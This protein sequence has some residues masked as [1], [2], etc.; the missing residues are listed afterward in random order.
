MNQATLPPTAASS[1]VGFPHATHARPQLALLLLL[2]GAALLAAPLLA[3]LLPFLG[4]A[5]SWVWLSLPGYILSLILIR[6]LHPLERLPIA[7]VLGKG[8]A[9]LYTVPAILGHASLPLLFAASVVMLA[10][11]L[12][13]Y[14]LAQRRGWGAWRPAVDESVIAQAPPP[15]Q[16]R[17]LVTALAGAV[18]LV[19]I[20]L[21]LLSVQWPA[22]GDDLAMLPFF[23]D[24]LQQGAI[25]NTEPFH[26]S[27]NPVLTRQELVVAV[28]QQIMLTWLTGLEPVDFYLYTRPVFILLAFLGLYALLRHALRRPAPALFILFLWSLYLLG[29]LLVEQTGSHFVTR[30]TQDKFEGWFAV[31]PPTLLLLMRFLESGSWVSSVGP[32]APPPP[33]PAHSHAYLVAFALATLGATFV[34]AITLPQLMTL[35]GSLWLLHGVLV[36]RRA[37][38]ALGW[39]ALVYLVCLIVP[40]IEYLRFERERLILDALGLLEVERF[41][42][43]HLAL[44]W[45]RLLLLPGNRFIVGPATFLQPVHYAGYLALPA[46]I[47]QLRRSALARLLLGAMLLLPLFLYTP[48]L[49]GLVGQL[50]PPSLM[51]RLAWPF[52]LFSI[53]AVGWAIWLGLEQLGQVIG[54][55]ARLVTPVKTGG[56][57]ITP[58]GLSL[59]SLL[60]VVFAFPTLRASW[61]GYQE[62]VGVEALSACSAAQHGL[63]DRLTQLS[64]GRPITVLATPLLNECLP[65]YI[66]SVQ[67][68]EYRDVATMARLY[69]VESREQSAQRVYDVTAF[70]TADRLDGTLLDALARWQVAY[71]LVD[72]DQILLAWQLRSL[73][74]LFTPAFEDERYILYAVSPAD[75][76]AV[77]QPRQADRVNNFLTAQR[78]LDTQHF[79]QAETQFRGCLE[80]PDLCAASVSL[81]HVGLAQALEGQGRLDEALAHWQAAVAAE[82][83]SAAL[84]VYLGQTHLLHQQPQAAIAAYTQALAVAPAEPPPS[85][86]NQ[87]ALAQRLA[88][89]TAAAWDSYAAGQTTRAPAGSATWYSLMGDQMLEHGWAA[90]AARSYEQAI[91]VE[92]TSWRYVSLGAARYTAGD[93]VG[94]LQAIVTARQRD[95][96]LS[97]APAQLAAIYEHQGWLDEAV[98]AYE[99]ALWLD[100]TNTVAFRAL[101]QVINRRHGLP[102]AVDET[103]TWLGVNDILPGPHDA[104]ADLYAE[105]GNYAAAVQ[106]LQFS[107]KVIPTNA[108][109]LETLGGYYFQ[110]E[111]FEAARQAYSDALTIYP[112]SPTA[113][114]G[115]NQLDG[116]NLGIDYTVGAQVALARRQPAAAQPHLSLAQL[117]QLAGRPASTLTR[118]QWA[119]QLNPRN[120]DAHLALGDLYLSQPS[121]WSGPGESWE[122][123]Q[124]SYQQAA[125]LTPAQADPHL[126]LSALYRQRGAPAEAAAALT[127]AAARQPTAAATLLAQAEQAQ[128]AGDWEAAR[129]LYGHIL[130]RRPHTLEA[131]L[132][133][134]ALERNQSQPQAA[135]DTLAVALEQHITD[136]NLYLAL[137][138]LHLALGRP[139]AAQDWYQAGVDNNPYTPVAYLG[140]AT[141][142]RR[143]GAWEAAGE[144]Y[145][146]ALRLDPQQAGAAIGLASLYEGQGEPDLAEDNFLVAIAAQPAS[147]WAHV[148]LGNF[149]QRQGRPAEAIA[150]YTAAQAAEPLYV[151]SYLALGN[152]YVLL[153]RPAEAEAQY[154]QATT[155]LPGSLPAWIGLGEFYNAQGRTAEALAAYERAAGLEPNHVG[156][157][158]SLGRAYLQ[159]G[160][161][162]AANDA[163]Q[164]AVDLAPGSAGAWY[165]LAQMHISRSQLPEAQSALENARR[166]HHTLPEVHT[167]LGDVWLR[168]G[169]IAQAITAYNQA[170]AAAPGRIDGLLRLA[171]LHQ[172]Q[173]AYDLALESYTT[174]QL[175][176]P[177]DSRP[178]LGLADIYRQQ[179]LL[180]TAEATLQ[181]GLSAVPGSGELVEQ[182]G[183]LYL[184]QGRAN[185][186]EALYRL[187]L[188]SENGGARLVTP[189]KTGGGYD[190]GRP[191][192]ALAPLS[193]SSAVSLAPF[194]SCPSCPS[195]FV[196]SAAPLTGRP[197]LHIALGSLLQ[198]RGD[199]AEAE[200][201]YRAAILAQ[202]NNARGYLALANLHL[203]LGDWQEVNNTYEAA[204]G[205]LP[206][207]DALQAGLSR[208]L[209]AQGE[210][211]SALTAAQQAVTYNGSAANLTLL[212]QAYENLGDFTPAQNAYESVI[213]ADYSLPDGYLALGRLHSRLGRLEEADVAFRQAIAITYADVE[214]YWRLGALQETLGRPAGAEEMY[215]LSLAA[216]S[217]D[218]DAH[219]RLAAFL[220]RQNRPQEAYTL[221]QEAL[222]LAP[223]RIDVHL[224]LANWYMAAGDWAAAEE[225]LQGAATTYPTSGL[226][227][228]A[229]ADFALQRGR[230]DEAEALYQQVALLPGYALDGAIALGN[231]HSARGRLAE[232]EAAFE[233]AIAAQPG[234]ARGYLALAGYYTGHG[235]QPE[236]EQVILGALEKM[237]TVE[238]LFVALANSQVQQGAH[239]AAQAT[240]EAGLRYHPTSAD[241]LLIRLDAC[242]QATI[243]VPPVLTQ[244]DAALART[245]G[246]TSLHRAQ[247]E[248]RLAAGDLTGAEAAYQQALALT[249]EEPATLIGLAQ[250]A[251]MQGATEAMLDYYAQAAQAS[252][253]DAVTLT[254]IGQAQ[255]ATGHLTEAA[256]AFDLALTANATYPGAQVGL[257][258]AL[259]GQGLLAEA[260]RVY[261]QAVA[262]NPGS[263]QALT[264][265]GNFQL[266]HLDQPTQALTLYQ[267]AL[268]VDATFLGAHIGLGRAYD[269]LGEFTAGLAAYEQGVAL[270]PSQ[271]WGYTAL[272][273]AYRAREDYPAAIA[274]HQ[275]ALALDPQSTSAHLALGGVYEAAGQ[276]DAA[277]AAYQAAAAL[278]PGSASAQLALGNVY[279]LQ[280][281]DTAA[282]TA[283][284]QAL[285]LDPDL[286]LAHER[287]G[288]FYYTRGN[289]L[290]AITYLSQAVALDKDSFSAPFLLALAYEKLGDGATAEVYFGVTLNRN[291]AY[292]PAFQGLGRTATIAGRYD[293]AIRHYT[294]ANTLAEN[295]ANY[296]AL[297]NVYFN[298]LHQ[299]DLAVA[300]YRQGI[301]LDPGC[302]FCYVQIGSVY[303]AQQDP[304]AAVAIYEAGIAAGASTGYLHNA[305]GGAYVALGE[306]EA[307]RQAYEAAVQ[308]DHRIVGA[309]NGIIAVFGRYEVGLGYTA[310]SDLIPTYETGGPYPLWQETLL[311][312][313]FSHRLYLDAAK[314]LTHFQQVEAQDPGFVAIYRPM[315][316]LYETLG[317][318]GQALTYWQKFLPGAVGEQRTEAENAIGRLQNVRLSSPAD[319][320]S[321]S[322]VVEVRGTAS[323]ANF[324][325]Y[326]VEY[327]YG[328]TPTTWLSI[329]NGVYVV[330]VHNN[331]LAYWDTT[332]LPAGVYTLRLTLVYR[333]GNTAPPDL[334]TVTVIN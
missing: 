222:T 70:A 241:L 151:D 207:S 162:V 152:L 9:T 214:P 78:A 320:Q 180:A 41:G 139:E 178:Y 52:P 25:S 142:L 40:I 159:S 122:G 216:D 64:A 322:G 266:N 201:E 242:A 129:T 126:R 228:D 248:A 277:V 197:G 179:G 33:Q 120:P 130:D 171:A 51:W 293:D 93:I 149:Y 29:T 296:L 323:A 88:G 205:V 234:N 74:A 285:A 124:A 131:Y 183:L 272:G 213:R 158:L 295:S 37:W 22:H 118:L 98:Q 115:L 283:Y 58:V 196:P 174:A 329:G 267:Q 259:E 26:G 165:A 203:G 200:A 275:Q 249:P 325:F 202:P 212:G 298:H 32:L 53:I 250:L 331:V 198:Q 36:G 99:R 221:Y 223:A 256:A 289:Y 270:N 276:T 269:A 128:T 278:D 271:A 265:L 132:A 150:T 321:V 311:G 224:A 60:V 34:H 90:E 302:E 263:P 54:D 62:R 301:A 76:A 28:Y 326:K 240:A 153:E 303:L 65:S 161:L 229:L 15:P 49:A 46:L 314:A 279:A 119:I 186:A 208:A 133:L 319:N 143:Q 284:E 254:Q 246:L 3:R 219:L 168:Q 308:R 50:V 307:A 225:T 134:S 109:Y 136:P 102:A 82:P 194:S 145:T 192:Q 176:Q 318:G 167:L 84:H 12:V 56:G 81:L 188:Y 312:Y 210:P 306:W 324:Q 66:G 288:N 290:G 69:A 114:S 287:L 185:D 18:A 310:V 191:L 141:E 2:S 83:D 258:Q 218:V 91:A 55:K 190:G 71:V 206:G 164:R 31:I 67:V 38:R 95:P 117:D 286:G 316:L 170:V 169:Q 226:A 156:L 220:E 116:R 85:L 80:T 252:L 292:A 232:A 299:P 86:W 137:G 313:I 75:A 125:A 334:V 17:L 268:A 101:A 8:L 330:P 100:P 45:E 157:W 148:A 177:A 4:V 255:L 104:L 121:L 144:A 243:C 204:L 1:G 14:L 147:G 163:Y 112:T 217:S 96:W 5:A 195:L 97:R 113:R 72:R 87:L 146:A 24:T 103:R 274:A 123:A 127:E 39:V 7:F 68:V 189:V 6:R 61:R 154:Q 233:A 182:L 187:A 297:G 199:G 280:F 108:G 21:A 309:Y 43:L 236:A 77:S 94:A 333:D 261:E 47:P 184:S 227:L 135:L 264:A 57:Y 172:S 328:S 35:G 294:T 48:L 160:Q 92:P 106:E 63:I 155:L 27:S 273:N 211:A 281:Q 244:L 175:I 282:L 253:N 42:R 10:V 173:G 305:L 238:A 245:P 111:Q 110:L 105:Q 304:A 300:A 247:A 262:V 235:R 19:I 44:F 251:E 13:G 166:A 230:W 237:P 79:T 23:Q 239:N 138:E 215:R 181:T 260:Q 193:S 140:L 315:A 73:P 107:L 59:I 30:I 291:P 11:T 327:G 317:D 209:M 89:Q 231:L 20:T 257:A 16:E 332:L